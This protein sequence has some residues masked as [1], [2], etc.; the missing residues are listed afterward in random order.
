MLQSRAP[1]PSV[2][3]RR[4]LALAA[5]LP[6]GLARAEPVLE[7]SRPIRILVPNAVGGTSDLLARLIDARL[8]DRGQLVIVEN[9]PGAAGRIALEHV[10]RAAPDGY[11]LLLGNN[12]TNAVAAG[13]EPAAEADIPALT[14]IIRLTSVAIVIAVIPALGVSTL[15]QL[16]ALARATPGQLS[17]ASG[18]VGSTSHLAAALLLRSA[19]VSMV[20]IPYAGTAAAVK[21]VLGGQVPIVFTQLGTIAP[22]LKSGQL[23]ALAVTSARRVAG[24][25]DIPTVAE[26]GF[27]G[28]AVT[29]WH[30]ILAP[31]GTPAD[32][33]ARLN[34][35]LTQV[36]ASPAVREQL[37]TLGMEAAATTPAAFASEIRAERERWAAVARDVGATGK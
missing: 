10:A 17:Y 15:A 25:R 1:A 30:G 35:A 6:L 2:G 16:L 20:Q 7:A 14:P 27:P 36:I 21:D 26:S 5:A 32:I 37:A 23:R 13:A 33:V 31:P 34:R 8:A 3:R 29:T 22:Y 28:F 18:G 24:F 9:R 12:G 4:L 19:G 11:T